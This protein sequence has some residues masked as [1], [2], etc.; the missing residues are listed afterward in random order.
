M[1]LSRLALL[2]VASIL[3]AVNL[4]GQVAFTWQAPTNFTPACYVVFHGTQSGAYSDLW[5]AGAGTNFTLT[6]SLPFGANYFAVA[7]FAVTNGALQMSSWSNEVVVTNQAALLLQSIFLT[8]TN[9]AGGAGSWTPLE[10]NHLLL[11]PTNA[12]RFFARTLTLT[13]T[14]QII[15]P[16]PP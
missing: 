3:L 8:T 11:A 16:M 9:L 7:D 12:A 5:N 1:I 10:T 4:F 15:V 14:N 2:V 13:R 6:A